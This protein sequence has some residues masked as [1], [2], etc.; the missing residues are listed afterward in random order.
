MY[1]ENVYIV[2]FHRIIKQKR[3][4]FIAHPQTSVSNYFEKCS[5]ENTLL[6][7]KSLSYREVADKEQNRNTD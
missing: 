4:S 7:A 5:N 1:R 3:R 6:A 2:H